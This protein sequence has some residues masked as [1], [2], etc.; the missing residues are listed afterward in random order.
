M[1]TE[2]E[3]EYCSCEKHSSVYSEPGEWGYWDYCSD[4]K[5]KIEDSYCSYDEPMLEDLY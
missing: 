4:C 5:K 2:K 1:I 3:Q